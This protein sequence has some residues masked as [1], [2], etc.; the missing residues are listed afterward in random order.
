MNNNNDI[1]MRPGLSLY[2]NPQQMRSHYIRLISHL[3]D[4][5]MEYVEI[6][7]NELPKEL[8]ALNPTGRLPFITDRDL[9]LYDERV[10]SEY[11]DER[12]PH[13][14]LMP[15]EANLRAKIRLFFWELEKHWYEPAEELL[16]QPKVTAAKRKKLHKQLHDNIIAMVPFFK[17]TEHLVVPELNLLD[18]FV[19]PLL[20][21]LGALE[22]EL[23]KSASPLFRYMDYH[24]SKD[25][26]IK[27][28]SKYEEELPRHVVV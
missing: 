20:W 28:L 21:R 14:A 15:I 5:E 17:N 25:Y 11:M 16:E 3:K 22:I 12:F 27:S 6:E 8:Q 19:L 18:C 7:G 1:I 23:P 4:L 10:I 26:F 2:S 24:F 9:V 13:P